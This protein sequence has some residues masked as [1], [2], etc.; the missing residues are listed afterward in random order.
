M[1]KRYIQRWM[2]DPEKIRSHKHLRFFG[3]FL[4][5]PGLWYLNRR[6]V[7]KA[8]WIGMFFAWVPVPF[9]MV[10]AAAGAI[11]FQANLPISIALVWITNPFTMPP[12]FYGAYLLGAWFLPENQPHVP[13]DVSWQWFVDSMEVIWP[14]FLLGCAIIGIGSSIIS[15]IFIRL[16]WRFLIIRKWRNR[17]HAP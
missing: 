6:S 1:P 13:T 9:Q 17:H 8:F 4:T 10:L 12:M 3:S 11:I 14:P 16:V 2:P 5:N 15:Y 7:A